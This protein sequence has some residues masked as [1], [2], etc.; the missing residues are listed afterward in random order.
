MLKSILLNEDSRENAKWEKPRTESQVKRHEQLS[1]ERASLLFCEH[2]GLN[3]RNSMRSSQ[4]SLSR[5]MEIKTSIQVYL[6]FLGYHLLFFCFLG[7]FTPL[8][9]LPFNFDKYWHLFSNMAMIICTKSI[10]SFVIQ[11]VNWLCVMQT[12]Y[13]LFTEIGSSNSM[14]LLYS[15]MIHALLRSS[16]IAIKYSTFSEYQM[17]LLDTKKINPDDLKK[18]LIMGPWRIQEDKMVIEWIH[19]AIHFAKIHTSSFFIRFFVQPQENTVL[20]LRQWEQQELSRDSSIDSKIDKQPAMFESQIVEDSSEDQALKPT[21]FSGAQ[22]FRFVL[23][24]VPK[25]KLTLLIIILLVAI[26]ICLPFMWDRLVFNKA[27]FSDCPVLTTR[28]IILEINLSLF[29]FINIA[30]Y[31]QAIIDIRRRRAVMKK[32]K[33]MLNPYMEKTTKTIL[34]IVDLLDKTSIYGWRSLYALNLEYGKKF[35]IRHSMFIPVVALVLVICTAL[36]YILTG[37]VS[38]NMQVN[39]RLI[40]LLT[41]TLSRIM[42]DLDIL[43]LMSAKLLIIAAGYNDLYEE[44]VEL[45]RMLAYKLENILQFSDEAIEHFEE[46][47]QVLNALYDELQKRYPD[48]ETRRRELKDLIKYYKVTIESLDSEMNQNVL[49]L[50]NIKISKRLLGSAAAVAL[51]FLLTIQKRAIEVLMQRIKIKNI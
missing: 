28:L 29:V 13:L 35:Y 39:S 4:F 21:Y 10:G 38:S 51:P 22:I 50:A 32:F 12:F 8:L 16:I 2:E 41:I 27:S 19:D 33:L 18:E 15:I 3:S 31:T 9:F 36:L 34:P 47:D 45:L 14:E 30:F 42:I 25:P 40:D 17:I 7:P 11:T 49:K 46:K 23:K 43:L 6:K 44:P 48:K 20:E 24:S 5:S 26:R 1:V 37:V